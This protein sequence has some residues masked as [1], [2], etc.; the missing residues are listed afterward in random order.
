MNTRLRQVHEGRIF[1]GFLVFSVGLALISEFV[2]ELVGGLG[3]KGLFGIGALLLAG[4]YGWAS[5]VWRK[6]WKVPTLCLTGESAPPSRVVVV[7][8]SV[9]GKGKSAA[10]AIEHHSP[11]LERAYVLHT[12]DALGH[13]AVDALRAGLDADLLGRLRPWPVA[14]VA[15]HDPL[16]VHRALEALFA[17]ATAAGFD[18]EEIVMDYTGGTRAFAAAMVLFAGHT[19]R[20]EYVTPQ[21]RDAQGRAQAELGHDVIEIDLRPEHR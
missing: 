8:A 4:I 14:P 5:Q 10:V 3:T 12:D 20:L 6:L 1:A 19:R 18:D 2:I 15:A 11:R 17:E 7:T 16:V 13:D 21:L 9:G